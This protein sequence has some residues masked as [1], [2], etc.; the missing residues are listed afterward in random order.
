MLI[1]F[2]GRISKTDYKKAIDMNLTFIKWLKW[3]CGGLLAIILFSN[4]VSVIRTPTILT[5]IFPSIIFPLVFLTFPWWIVSLQ[6]ASFDQKGNIY[7]SPINGLIDE[8]GV[9]INGQETKSHTLWKAYTHYKKNDTLVL[10]YQGKSCFNIF[11]SNLF[12][13]PED[14]EKFLGELNLKVGKTSL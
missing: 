7:R 4:I 6:A 11:T 8:T 14:W 5:Y 10:L 1:Y 13:N 3:V 9:S 2:Q 12:E